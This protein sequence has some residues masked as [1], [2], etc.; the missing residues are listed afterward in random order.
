M[1]KT[2][3]TTVRNRENENHKKTLMD[4]YP[5]VKIKQDLEGREY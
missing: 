1:A 2:R 5:S 3:P 4:I